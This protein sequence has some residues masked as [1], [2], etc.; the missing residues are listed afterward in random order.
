MLSKIHLRYKNTTKLKKQGVRKMHGETITK[1]KAEVAIM[2]FGGSNCYFTQKGHCVMKSIDLS[3]KHNNYK[4]IFTQQEN[5]KIHEEK[6]LQ[7]S[8]F[9]FQTMKPKLLNLDYQIMRA[10]LFIFPVF[11]PTFSL[12]IQCS[13]HKTYLQFP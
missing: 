2:Y 4:Y 3:G 12:T 6:H 8:Q 5:P 9:T 11:S 10:S 7:R 1:K 13:L